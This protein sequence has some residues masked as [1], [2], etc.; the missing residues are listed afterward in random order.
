MVGV[1]VNLADIQKSITII[2]EG[3]LPYE[4]RTT[5]VP[6]WHEP[7]D[8]IGMGEMITG[9]EKWYLQFFKSDTDLVDQELKQK[10]AFTHKEMEA[11]AEQGKQYAIICQIRG[12]Q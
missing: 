3:G 5:I 10:P 7:S 12:N 1:P 4:F 2:K 9:A 11:M 8:I 6:G